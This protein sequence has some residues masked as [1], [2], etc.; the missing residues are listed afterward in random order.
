ESVPAGA[1]ETSKESVPAGAVETSKE[2]VPAAGSVPARVKVEPSTDSDP[3]GAVEPG[4]THK[5]KPKPDRNNET[6]ADRRSREAH[7]SYMRYYRSPNCPEEV[8]AKALL[9]NGQKRSTSV[10]RHMYEM[11]I[12][13]DCDWMQ[14]SIVLNAKKRNST[15]RHG[16]AIAED[17]RASKKSMDPCGKG[18]WWKDWELFK[19]F[20]SR[21]EVSESE[22]ELEF[23]F[24]GDVGLD[25]DGTT[26]VLS[27]L[28]DVGESSGARGSNDPGPENPRPPPPNPKKPRGEK[29]AKPAPQEAMDLLARGTQRIIEADGMENMLRT[30][31]MHLGSYH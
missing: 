9:P 6:E 4:V 29:K 8:R 10:M 17:I 13:S 7:N 31:G 11:W 5:P 19:C 27:H 22:D 23:G 20:D 26:G 2:S 3:A 28:L 1:A 18:K 30:G 12:S 14:S 24:H 15:K 21:E 25:H 16:A